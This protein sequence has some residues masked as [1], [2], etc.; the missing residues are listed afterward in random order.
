MTRRPFF[1]ISL[2]LPSALV[3][4]ACI[5]AGDGVAPPDYVSYFPV[6][7][8]VDPTDKWLYVV[9]SDFDLQFS[10]GTLQSLDMRRILEIARHPCA[11][12][13]DCDV[14]AFGEAQR[15]DTEESDVNDDNPSFLCVDVAGKYAGLPCGPLPENTPAARA[16]SPGRCGP[17]DLGKP[18]DG[19]GS[20]QVDSVSIS[21]FATDLLLVPRPVLEGGAEVPSKTQARLFLPV[22]G[23][24]S[25][26]FVDVEAGK[27]D[28][29]Q[30]NDEPE[31]SDNYRVLQ[32]VT[33]DPNVY[34]KTPVEPFGLASTADGRSLVMTHQT[35]GRASG[36]RND[37]STQSDGTATPPRLVSIRDGMPTNPVGVASVP[38]PAYVD[39]ADDTL[40]YQSGFLVTFRTDASVHLLRFFEP[41]LGAG[42]A[43]AAPDQPLLF[44]VGRSLITAN[45]VGSD[46]RGIAIDDSTR[47]AAENACGGEVDCLR[48]AASVPLDVYVANRTPN[49]LL[50]GRTDRTDAPVATSDLPTFHNNIPL[51]AGPSRVVIGYVIGHDGEPA[52]RVFVLC[53]DSALIYVYDPTRR[54]LEPQ[55]IY[56]GRGPHSLAFMSRDSKA[57]YAFVGHFTDSYV[58]VIS[59]DQRYP[60][61]FGATLAIL[62]TPTPP[63][64]SR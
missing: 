26:H 23:D 46:S 45:S 2:A 58:A 8:A 63:R 52:L 64:A 17:V 60:E 53:F 3:F 36:F 25:L 22:R 30:T 29:G 39:L 50:I 1:S 7:L 56:T 13:A 41:G 54:G 19:R 55:V 9:N 21:A 40:N 35:T 4:C 51:T 12:D 59:L 27:L 34:L 24:S 44:D 16:V 43:S 14:S 20:L 48:K 5:P 6:G 15:C 10:Q 32:S 38:R 11:T 28:C 42:G 33:S 62:G 37:W 61:T 57:P 47:K 18:V 31:C 49:S